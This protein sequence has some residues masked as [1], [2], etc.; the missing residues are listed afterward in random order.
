MA[1]GKFTP[2]PEL[3]PHILTRYWSRVDKR[4]PDDCWLW[5]SNTNGV[6]YGLLYFGHSNR[7]LA[8]RVAYFLGYG[9]DPGKLCVCH[10]CDTPACQNPAH[11]FL[12]SHA[13]NHHD[14]TAKGRRNFGGFVRR[15]KEHP[16]TVPCGEK[17][18]C[19][20]LKEAD[21]IEIRR[22]YATGTLSQRVLGER[23]GVAQSVVGRILN[24]KIWKSVA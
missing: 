23:F 12:G 11:L 15:F 9:V 20:K 3:T 4:G 18:H 2:F 16:E 24:R 17:Q 21:V 5:K 14:C 13:D 6:G 1:R 22:L 8:H 10:R 19:A 7:L